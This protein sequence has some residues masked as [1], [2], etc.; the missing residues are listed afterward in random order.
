[1]AVQENEYQ[2]PVRTPAETVPALLSRAEHGDRAA[3]GALFAVL[4]ADLH[5]LAE[6]HVRRGAGNVT[7]GATTLLHEAYVQMAGRESLSFADRARF[8]AYAS[9]AMRGLVINAVR[10]RH[11]D[12]RGG[13]L[14]FTTLDDDKAPAVEQAAE[15]EALSHALDELNDLEPPLVELVDLKFFC[16]FSFAEIAQMRGVSE[17]TVQRD[18]A[19]ARL[20]L[21]RALQD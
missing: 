18:W 10:D 12:K 15:L 1:M 13:A 2:L 19:R 14:T 21:R 4:Y 9:R 7:L 17:R 16:G 6:S 20:L 3:R 8:F 5:R 11:A